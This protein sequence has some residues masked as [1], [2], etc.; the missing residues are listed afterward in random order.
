MAVESQLN[1]KKGWKN[2][3]HSPLENGKVT[4]GES[5]ETYENDLI[6]N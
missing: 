1:H 2:I 3:F 5:I 6:W 4:G